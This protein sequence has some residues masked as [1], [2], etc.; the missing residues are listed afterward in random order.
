MIHVLNT[1][2]DC[3]SRRYPRSFF[4]Y[5][6]VLRGEVDLDQGFMSRSVVPCTPYVYC[7]WRQVSWTLLWWLNKSNLLSNVALEWGKV[8][9]RRKGRKKSAEKDD[10][11][12]GNHYR[13]N[14]H[15]QSVWLWKVRVRV[16][17]TNTPV[18]PHLYSQHMR[19]H[20]MTFD[21]DTR[22]EKHLSDHCWG[23]RCTMCSKH[24]SPQYRS[25]WNGLL[26]RAVA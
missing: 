9:S 21:S 1:F 26:S 15:Y 17:R 3:A 18:H 2:W 22:K 19:A 25:C 4:L 6:T 14:L 13:L 12:S 16:V 24:A 23:A 5:S 20:S 10:L 11:R 7:L 8:L